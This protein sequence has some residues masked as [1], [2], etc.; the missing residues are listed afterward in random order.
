MQFKNIF[1]LGLLAIALVSLSSCGDN[2][3]ETATTAERTFINLG[4]APTGG[5]FHPV[6]CAAA[7]VVSENKGD[8]N[9]IVTP[10]G[11]KGTQENIR[12]LDDE[13][14]Q[15]AMANAAISYF[16]GRG[17]GAWEKPYDIRTVAT[18]APNI[19]IF[20]T[21]EA[22]GIKTLA[23]LKGKRVVL[24]PSGAGFDYFLKPL[25]EAHGVSYDDLTPLNGNYIDA[26]D[27]LADGKADAAFMGGA[28]PIP[29]VVQLCSTQ[30]VVFLPFDD[31]VSEKLKQYPF[32]SAVT[33]P[34]DTYSD[35]DEDLT[36]IN[37][38]NM[39]LITHANVDEDV[40]YNFTKI[41]YEN[42][43]Q[44]AERHP[45][46]KAINPKNAIRNTGTPFHPGAIKYYKEA[47]IWPSD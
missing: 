3:S 33:L 9:W 1:S 28:I 21:T 41:M 30:D 42:R 37:V 47:G 24:G 23:D 17:E 26:G 13:E 8:L 10:Q 31:A 5:A 22:S 2:G 7:N 20:V 38:G 29:A 4:T 16:A 18:I 40:V 27:M 19:G 36:G 43:E 44:M 12:R 25:L 14:L 34:A 32:Y 35:L 45:A 6:G 11:T 39:Q 46:A 15:F